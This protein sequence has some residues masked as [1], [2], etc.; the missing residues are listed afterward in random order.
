MSSYRPVDEEHDLEDVDLTE[1]PYTLVVSA[2]DPHSLTANI[3]ALSNHLANPRVKVCLGDLAS[4]L[5]ERRSRFWHRA[6]ITSRTT[7]INEND[8]TIGKNSGQPPKIA[9]V[10]TGQG[11]QWPQMGKELLEFFPWTGSIL[12]ELDQVLQAQTNPPNWSLVSELTKPRTAEH[13]RQP[14][15]SQ[16]LVTALQ[17]CLIAVLESWGVKASSVVGHSSGEIAAAY[18]AGYLDRA[19]AI[20]AA[21]YRGRAAE[22]CK[23][24]AHSDVGMLAVGLG[25]EDISEYMKK[26]TGS[27]WIACFNS[28]T[29]L[30]I[31]GKKLALEAMAEEL[32]AAGHFARLLQVDLA[33]HTELMSV[34]AEEYDKLLSRD[35]RFNLLGGSCDVTMFSSV[36]GLKKEGTTDAQYWKSNMV[37]PVRFGE[38]LKELVTKDT[39]TMIIEVGPSGALSGPVSQVLKSVPTGGDILYCAAWARGAAAGKSLF[40]V[41]GRLFVTG[42]PI[43]MSVVN[44]YN[45]TKVRTII[46]LPNYSW[47]HS[48]KYW[49]ENAASKDWRNKKFVNHDLLGSKIPGT[50]WE[51]SPTWRQHLNLADIPWLRD[52]RMGP[53]VLVPGAGLATMA[54]EAMYQK[55]RSLNPDEGI[56]SP[57]D[58][59]YRFR[60]VRFDRAVV[61]EERKP[62]TVML[63]LSKVPNSKDWHEFRIQ[64]SSTGVIHDHCSGLIR[65]QDPVGD[66]EALKH[67]ELAPLEHPQSA[68]LWY[69]AQREAGMGFGPTFQKIKSIES[70]SG[71]RTCRT[72]VSMQPPSSKWDPQSYYPVH[73]AVLDGCLQTAT[74]ATVA[75]ERSF[76]KDTMIPALLDDMIIN[77]MPKAVAEG[78]SV[79]ESIYSGRGRKDVAKNWITNL[80]IHH[81]DTGALLLRVKG[82]NYVKLDMDRKPD[83][84]VFH[85]ATWKPDISLLTQDQLM[86]L[87]PSDERSTRVNTV[88]DLIAQKKPSLRVLEINLDETDASTMWFL[89]GDKSLRAAYSQYDF[90]S[91]N[92]KVLVNVQTANESKRNVAFYLA[93]LTAEDLGLPATE[94]TYDLVI[95]KA[96]KTTRIAIERLFNSLK[97]F[98]KATAFTLL[99]RPEDVTPLNLGVSGLPKT[100]D[101]PSEVFSDSGSHSLFDEIS[102]GSWGGCTLDPRSTETEFLNPHK[103]QRLPGYGSFLEIVNAPGRRSAYLCSKNGDVVADEGKHLTIARFHP[104]FRAIAPAL[105]ATLEA[106]GWSI[107]TSSIDKLALGDDENL[108][109]VI[110]VLDDLSRSIL[111]GI[112]E[113][114]WEGLKQ[115]IS[116]GASILWVTKGGQTSQVTEPDNALIQ[117]LFRVVR[118]E[119]PQARLTTLDVQSS[120]SPATTWAIDQILQKLRTGAGVETEYA[121][122]DGM[123]LLQRVK[124]DLPINDFKAAESGRGLEQVIKGLHG[125]E[126][127]V[128]IQAEKIGTLQSLTWC[129]TATGEVPMDPGMVEIEVVAIGVN[130]KVSE[131][132]RSQH[133]N[134]PKPGYDVL[135]S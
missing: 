110:L 62:T 120:T 90:A 39:P 12:A 33:Y 79:S 115:V 118:R 66:D 48:V 86:Y 105:Q 42:A 98:I 87:S 131:S 95:V 77:K 52:H 99:V 93:S 31:S 67:E 5:S 85:T 81:P 75:G 54:L 40:D 124:P 7:E 56:S 59:S 126:A 101:T 36:T 70:V 16:P 38:A 35:N 84:H 19:G 2:N 44:Q 112:P 23:N 91:T 92:A 133:A 78:L 53:D 130:F 116:T 114:Q 61:V 103:M 123:L 89:G 15:F 132:E 60:N 29:S 32:K 55:H 1:R 121:E 129:E 49:H 134:Q 102:D 106:S 125:T 51:A 128:R 73:P 58:L 97:P 117:G 10:F 111:T 18:A 3:L 34:I 80:A 24:E 6:F 21:F 104:G 76:I 88:I 69:K 22:N 17:L 96:P 57:N 109:S 82:L 37:S 135:T 11:S 9:I 108:K 65:V 63:T 30:T 27:A 46:D 64:T 113:N 45:T 43:N 119:N 4:T 72:I 107:R 13:L 47:N 26:Y 50:T 20:K 122:R 71:S 127:Q 83:P 28:P 100:P 41:A 68:K 74:P 8:F 14:G 94:P 25:P